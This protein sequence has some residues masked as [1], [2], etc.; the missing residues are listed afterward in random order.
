MVLLLGARQVGKTTL[1]AHELGGWAR[2]DLEDAASAAR[3]ADD[4]ALF[5]RDH[6]DSVWF[7]EAHRV[8]ELFPALRVAVDRDRRPGRFV[9][10]GSATGALAQEASQSLAGRTGLLRL[11]PFSV[12]E[13]REEPPSPFLSSLLGSW[14]ASEALASVQGRRF[15]DDGELGA[16]WFHGGLPEPA[17]LVNDTR[18]RRW[19]DSYIRLVAERDLA[20]ARSDLRPG[21]VLRLLRLLAARQGQ[22]INLSSLARDFGVSTVKISA[23]LDLLEG[24]FLWRRIEPYVANVGK[25]IVKSPKGWIADA[26]LAHALLELRGPRD[27]EVHPGVGASWEGWVLQQLRA[28]A[29]L[30]DASPRFY[31][32]RTHAGAEVDLVIEY[33]Q[34]LIPIEIKRGTRVSP[35]D[36]RGLR[37]F[38]EAFGQRVPVG[39]VLYR[40]RDA[41]RASEDVVLLPMQQAV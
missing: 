9:L 11:S 22:V 18:W 34:R 27:L 26:G 38:M 19:F 20:R 10:S 15:L 36:L 2:V 14:D 3:L 5:L 35:Y 33:Q 4:P 1:L 13:H 30:L 41:L 29:A 7:D 40:G 21:P 31:H 39:V 12:A 37:S 25:R 23:F 16:L 8:P 6:P 28:Q 17:L 32:W 24:A